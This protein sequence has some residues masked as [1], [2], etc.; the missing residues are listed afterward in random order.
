M[1]HTMMRRLQTLLI[2]SY[3][4]S[5]G[6]QLGCAHKSHTLRTISYDPSAITAE[7]WSAEKERSY[8]SLDLA[9]PEIEK[10]RKEVESQL[11]YSLKNRGE[12][13]VTVITPP[14]F[15][16]LKKHLS[17]KEIEFLAQE[18][19]LQKTAYQFLC[20]GKG[21]LNEGN[22]NE[23]TFYIVIQSER[24]F[25]IREAIHQLYVKKGGKAED[26]NAELYYPHITL[27]YTKRDLH[28]EEGV[29][30]DA[31]SCIYGLQ[32]N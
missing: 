10:I 32:K 8:L 7:T 27:G 16:K 31:S 2:F 20:V 18:M 15:A 5:L 29:K 3:L 25:Q 24:L 23:N 22:K 14:E 9:Y 28:L 11:G 30:K 13:H 17:M 6:F 1:M 4:G 21:S 12:A 26:F 19:G